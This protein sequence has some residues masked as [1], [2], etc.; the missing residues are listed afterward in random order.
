MRNL[1]KADLPRCSEPGGPPG[2]TP[3]FP[4]LGGP[5][6]ALGGGSGESSRMPKR[7]VFGVGASAQAAVNLLLRGRSHMSLSDKEVRLV[8]IALEVNNSYYI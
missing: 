2:R 7:G 8:E 1:V 5:F 6:P 3:P 4:S